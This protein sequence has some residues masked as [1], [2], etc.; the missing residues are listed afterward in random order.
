MK[1]MLPLLAVTLTACT[2]QVGYDQK[3]YEFAEKAA[4]GDFEAAQEG[5]RYCGGNLRFG[6]ISPAG[7][8]LGRCGGFNALV[9]ENGLMSG[10][11]EKI[12]AVFDRTYL[13]EDTSKYETEFDKYP[14]R[15]E[16]YL[17]IAKYRIQK[18]CA[19]LSPPVSCR[20]KPLLKKFGL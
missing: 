18:R 9:I 11:P 14:K 19:E 3:I 1:N 7:V 15:R 17:D 6:T 16:F 10:D 8:F 13:N 20:N 2:D 5:S 12:N 4:H